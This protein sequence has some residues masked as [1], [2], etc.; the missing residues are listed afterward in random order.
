[1]MI[2]INAAEFENEVLKSQLPVVVDCYADW[3]GP[4]KMMKPLFDMMANQYE[5]KVKFC[6]LNV[7]NNTEIAMK[8]KVASIPNFLCFKNGQL[9][10]NLVGA[11]TPDKFEDLIK[12]LL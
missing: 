7:D 5:G 1:M 3:C 4:C 8:Y 9:V 6:S 11:T 2:T 10:N 12:S